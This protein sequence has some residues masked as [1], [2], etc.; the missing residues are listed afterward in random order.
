V[1]KSLIFGKRL[2]SAFIDVVLAL[3]VQENSRNGSNTNTEANK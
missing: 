3:K 2:K 1:S